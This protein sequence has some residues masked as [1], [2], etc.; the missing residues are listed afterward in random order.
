MSSKLY[1]DILGLARKES[2]H[3][4]HFFVGVEHLFIALTRIEGGVAVSALEE[5]GVAPRF[6]RYMLRQELGQGDNRRFWPGFRETPRLHTVL[7]MAR[8]LALDN[9]RKHPSERDLFLAILREG[10]SLPYRVLQQ[11]DVNL[12]QLEVTAA[13]WTEHMRVQP[14]RV[15]IEFGPDVHLNETELEVI[16]QMFR[17]NYERVVIDRHLQG[18]YSAAKVLVAHPY[19]A[20]GRPSAP[21]VVKLD[22]RQAILYE[23]MRY[24]SYVR[25]TLPP[26]TSRV[27]DNPIVP[28]RS[29]L[30]GLKYT[31]IRDPEAAGPIDL[32]DYAREHG[33]EALSDLLWNSLYRVFGETW[34]SQR[35]LYQFSVWQEYEMLLPPALVVELVAEQAV[36]RRRLVPLGQ[37]SRRGRFANG[38]LVALEGFTVSDYYPSRNGIQLASG[39][40][41]EAQNRAGKVE[42]RGISHQ[43]KEYYRG[44][45]IDSLIGR[46][47]YTRDDLLFKQA[48]SL[49]PNFDITADRLPSQA[50]FGVQLP[51]PLKRYPNLLQRRIA[52]SL[53]T[54]HGDLHLHNILVGPGG[55]AWLIDFALTRE[56]HTLFDW[57]V[58]ETSL[59]TEIVSPAIETDAW[60]DIWPVVRML[61]EIAQTGEPPEGTLP[62][63]RALLVIAS[64]RGIVQECLAD[65]GDW[66]EYNVALA[67]CA[68][69]G[70][71]WTE[72]LSLTSRRLLFLVSALAMSSAGGRSGMS[73]STPDMDIT[74][75][76]LDVTDA[77]SRGQMEALVHRQSVPVVGDDPADSPG[78]EKTEDGTSGLLRFSAYHPGGI[79]TESWQPFNVYVYKS[80]AEGLV[81]KDAR[82]GHNGLQAV[83]A[84]SAQPGWPGASGGVQVTVSPHLPG[85][86]F[87]PAAA[88]VLLYEDWHRFE[89]RVLASDIMARRTYSGSVTVAFDGIIVGD[90]PVTLAVGDRPGAEMTFSDVASPYRRI[91]CSYSQEDSAIAR[92]IEKLASTLGSDY[93]QELIELRSGLRWTDELKGMLERAD[94][95][96]L[97]WSRNAASGLF[98]AQEWR[99]ALRMPHKKMFM[100]PIYWENPL[101]AL[102]PELAHM[103]FLHVPDLID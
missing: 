49:D 55:N 85:F 40:G 77:M 97:F 78:L 87:N 67:L 58:L 94:I 17:G 47:L 37:W 42:V 10:D 4:G 12:D 100:R 36:P 90:I 56:G 61:H 96:Q 27:V 93:L 43:P 22:E 3:A 24:D 75:A 68:M 32:A 25:D 33:P 54:I 48:V 1:D 83:Y 98:V 84:Q 63:Q 14:V 82:S 101:P 102:P 52:G 76:H 59:L 20:D 91:Y 86:T 80:Y 95:F 44:A 50:T 23:K 7:R 31:F 8:E 53:S 28:D 38:E 21:V 5:Q 39:S 6:V 57:A 29:T 65:P 66:R 74:D 2:A 16:Q 64:L 26:A 72:T 71:R 70:L 9:S 51:N 11:M 79:M 81:S 30:G 92:R 34:W 60:E 19:R 35:H 45:V 18:G 89:F 62:V 69:R 46:V 88:S 103:T 73:T 15:P 13:N 99:Q 41:P